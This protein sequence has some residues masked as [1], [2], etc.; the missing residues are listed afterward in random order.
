MSLTI[1]IYVLLGALII[2]LF[3]IIYLIILYKNKSKEVME[4]KADATKEQQKIILAAQKKAEEI[5][6][7]AVDASES[8]LYDTEA[9]KNKVEKELKFVLKD[10]SEKRKKDFD[11]LLTDAF[12]EFKDQFG[13]LRNAY[14]TQTDATAKEMQSFVKA[15][16]DLLKTQSNEK[17]AFIQSYIEE[18]MNGE[19]TKMQ[20][21]LR[22]YKDQQMNAFQQ[23]L[24][25]RVN[26]VSRKV[27][28]GSISQEKQD[29]LLLAALESA[30]KDSIL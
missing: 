2:Q 14:Q 7:N 26:E 28:Q 30:K 3:E 10:V 18:K 27:L 23:Q 1:L 15:E 24:K 6:Q 29:E 13:T 17:S 20:E 21:E 9:F 4:V 11:E 16:L 12:K 8:I 25:D 5:V 22:L 19:F